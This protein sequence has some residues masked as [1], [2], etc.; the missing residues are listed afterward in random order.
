MFS[1]LVPGT[2]F[3]NATKDLDYAIEESF[4]LDENQSL[5]L[6]ISI[7]YAPIIVTGYTIYSEGSVQNI[8]IAFNPDEN[9]ENNTAQQN[10]VLSN[11]D[12]YYKVGLMPGNYNVVVNFSGEQG[13]FTSENSL[14][15][16]VGKGSM[17]FDIFMDKKSFTISGDTKYEGRNIGNISITFSPN[18]EI[19][20]N[21]AEFATMKSKP[22]GSYIVELMP[23]EY[24]LRGGSEIINESGLEFK[25]VYEGELSIASDMRYDIILSKE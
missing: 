12:G 19:E 9:I 24:I 3:I 1:D 14:I 8:S 15:L 7:N 20:N 17:V 5:S 11:Q 22:D 18:T 13:S 4:G 16:D 6:N 25:Y 2:Y 23:G 21:T 10:Q